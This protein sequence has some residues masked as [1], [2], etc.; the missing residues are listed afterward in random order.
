MLHK[1]RASVAQELYVLPVI[2]ETI[3]TQ[4]SVTFAQCMKTCQIRVIPEE[5]LEKLL[6]FYVSDKSPSQSN[7]IT[8]F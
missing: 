8:H 3:W 6:Q 7:I 2:F 5:I 1:S 4:V